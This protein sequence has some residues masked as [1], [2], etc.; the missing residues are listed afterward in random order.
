MAL[1]EGGRKEGREKAEALACPVAVVEFIHAGGCF[2]YG[3]L[4]LESGF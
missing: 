3:D 2:S 4:A 1:E